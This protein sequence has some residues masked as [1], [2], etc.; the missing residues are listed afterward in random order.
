MDNSAETLF[1]KA[2][3]QPPGVA[4]DEFLAR[5][6]G[7]NAALRREVESLVRAHE[8]AG[9][10]LRPRS[11]RVE[12]RVASQGTAILNAAGYA[13][14]YLNGAAPPNPLQPEAYVA[15]LPEA[16]RREA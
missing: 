7:E 15:A 12:P 9:D 13:E 3:E 8:Q 4:R 16:V 1:A 6:C 2:V 14:A 10:F 5:A 11:E